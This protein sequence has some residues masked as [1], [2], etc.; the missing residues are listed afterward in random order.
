MWFF[1]L[2]WL[3]GSWEYLAVISIAAVVAYVIKEVS[4]ADAKAKRRKVVRAAKRDC[5]VI[6]DS[7]G[8]LRQAV[9]IGYSVPE[10][11]DAD[12]EDNSD[13]LDAAYLKGYIAQSRKR[14]NALLL[15]RDK[16]LALDTNKNSRT[17]KS[18]AYDIDYTM[19]EIEMSQAM[20]KEI[21]H[22]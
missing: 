12:V 9:V 18:N 21:T 14:L 1:V 6:A 4:K 7:I 19:N 11:A 16:L 17:W 10:D 2:R 15:R 8:Q 3:T 13:E 5:G 22:K 20:L